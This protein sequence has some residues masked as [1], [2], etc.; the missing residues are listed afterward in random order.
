MNPDNCPACDG[1]PTYLGSLGRML[2]LRCRQCGWVW[3]APMAQP[4]VVEF[5]PTMPMEAA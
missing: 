1:E 2:H 3:A 4:H 5:D